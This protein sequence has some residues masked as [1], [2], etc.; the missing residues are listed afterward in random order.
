MTISMPKDRW[1][2][3]FLIIEYIFHKKRGMQKTNKKGIY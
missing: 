1:F 3:G 2:Y